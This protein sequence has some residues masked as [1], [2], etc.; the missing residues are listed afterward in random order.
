MGMRLKDCHHIASAAALV[1]DI[2]HKLSFILGKAILKP[3]ILIPTVLSQNIIISSC[4]VAEELKPKEAIHV[5]IYCSVS[6][7]GYMATLQHELT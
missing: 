6:I 7:H 5:D 4:D 3:F 2:M 1:F